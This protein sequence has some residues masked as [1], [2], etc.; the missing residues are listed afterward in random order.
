MVQAEFDFSD[1]TLSGEERL[2]DLMALTRGFFLA[3]QNLFQRVGTYNDLLEEELEDRPG[4]IEYLGRSRA[5]VSRALDWLKGFQSVVP[6]AAEVEKVDL[7]PVLEGVIPR[8]RKILS[9]DIEVDLRL[10]EEATI[11]H[12]AVFQLQDL[13][14]E[15]LD[16][17]V[18]LLPG[19]AAVLRAEPCALQENDLSLLK[20]PCRAGN[21]V[22]ITI[23]VG[24]K[25]FRPADQINFWEGIIE[26]LGARSDV[27]LRLLHAYGIMRAHAGDIFFGRDGGVPSLT[28]V[29]PVE[30]KR[31]DMQVVPNI[32]DERLLGSETILLVDDEDMI[33]DVIIDMLQEL[34]YSVILA[35]NGLEAVEVYRENPGIIDLVMLDMVMP[36]MDGHKTFF[37]LKEIDPD[38]CVLLSSGYVSEED[39][40]DVL[41]AGAAGFLQKPYRMVDLAR[42]V[43]SILDER[44]G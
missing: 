34:G 7:R 25:A 18:P 20:S 13:F 9:A 37:S 33:W 14:F 31:K 1:R 42:R 27:G 3:M 11:V 38:V 4:A 39:A 19:D 35:G 44:A 15:M 43:R 36:E 24:G 17:Y 40:R 12:G 29:L 16:C 28:L 23:G 21:C 30:G 10:D 5:A 32:G 8:C 22:A 26:E 6:G 41:D 2:A